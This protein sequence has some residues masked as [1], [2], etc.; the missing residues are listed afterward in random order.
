MNQAQLKQELG[1]LFPEGRIPCVK[2][3]ELAEKYN[4][5]CLNMG[6]LLDE[7][8]IKIIKCQLGCF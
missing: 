3:F 4:I 7:L 5:S 6:E 1:E 8:K 2:V